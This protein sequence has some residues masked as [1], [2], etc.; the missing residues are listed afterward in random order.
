VEAGLGGYL[1]TW[2]GWSA[3]TWRDTDLIKSVT[4]WTPINTPAG[5]IQDTTHN[6]W[7]STCKGFGLVVE[8]EAKPS[9]ELS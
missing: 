2:L 3:N 8:A 4:P 5:G 7:F 1:A 9:R 6:L